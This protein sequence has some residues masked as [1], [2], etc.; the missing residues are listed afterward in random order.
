MSAVGSKVRSRVPSSVHSFAVQTKP[1]TKRAPPG[2]TA[3]AKTNALCAVRHDGAL[4]R[5]I[6][7]QLDGLVDRAGD[8][9]AVGRRRH[10]RHLHSRAASE[11]ARPCRERRPARLH[12]RA[13]FAPTSQS[14]WHAGT[15]MS[16]GRA[17]Q[18][19]EHEA[20]GVRRRAIK[21]RC[22]RRRARAPRK[23][24]LPSS[25][26]R[27]REPVSNR[28]GVVAR[29]S[30]ELTSIVR[31]WNAALLSPPRWPP[32]AKSAPTSS[33]TAAHRP[34]PRA[35]GRRRR[36]C[37]RGSRSL[38]RRLCTPSHHPQPRGASCARRPARRRRRAPTTRAA[39]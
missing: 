24:L 5:A 36:R 31:C 11:R 13:R 28:L 15:L 2:S 18:L 33:R 21:V 1:L 20:Q 8:D 14:T 30:R 16:R 27:R 7:P 19:V 17:A 25:T 32:S 12:C 34:P 29:C 10:A 38:R 26:V 35:R 6:A 4:A 23:L 9:A 39:R 22:A 3:N 37:G